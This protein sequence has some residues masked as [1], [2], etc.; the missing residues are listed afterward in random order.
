MTRAGS[1]V[2]E[3][4]SVPPSRKKR[5]PPATK[6]APQGLSANQQ[7]SPSG[8]RSAGPSAAT[9]GRKRPAPPAAAANMAPEAFQTPKRKRPAPDEEEVP[10]TAPPL[11]QDIPLPEEDVF[12]GVEVDESSS[13]ADEPIDK[14]PQ[15]ALRRARSPSPTPA[16]SAPAKRARMA[17]TR[18][19]AK[20]A[21]DGSPPKAPRQKRSAAKQSFRSEQH[22]FIQK[23]TGYRPAP[24]RPSI[25]SRVRPSSTHTYPP[26]V[27]SSEG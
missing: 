10:V 2:L 5:A 24:K 17:P 3:V 22:Y 27:R 6:I 8:S 7:A 13:L 23:K 16:H 15:R 12:M 26:R 18:R 14:Q 9:T 1:A 20:Q 11:P 4:Q 21:A 19:A 25:K